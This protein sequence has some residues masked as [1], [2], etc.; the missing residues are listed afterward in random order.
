MT[1]PRG[2][3]TQKQFWDQ[4]PKSGKGWHIEDGMI[5]CA[6]GWCPILAVY[7]KVRGGSGYH[8]GDYLEAADAL[9]LRDANF[10]R[11]IVYAADGSR[12][13]PPFGRSF[14]KRLL[15]V[16]SLKEEE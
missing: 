8:N 5:R 10:V 13:Y 1:M 14:R 15:R 9:G 12:L 11:E 2:K 7:R 16:L 6:K 4:L 3:M